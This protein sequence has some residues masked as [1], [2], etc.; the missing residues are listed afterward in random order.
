MNAEGCGLNKGEVFST[1]DAISGI[2][3]KGRLTF[4][5]SEREKID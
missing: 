1:I 4:L 5:V 2:E 3:E